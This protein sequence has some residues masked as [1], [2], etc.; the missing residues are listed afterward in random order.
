M[1]RSDT[2]VLINTHIFGC[3]IWITFKTELETKNQAFNEFY[4]LSVG[5]F[6]YKNKN[7]FQFV[8]Y[9]YDMGERTY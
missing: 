6:I 3:I 9:V 4:F 1:T 5:D 7:W 2:F 8:I